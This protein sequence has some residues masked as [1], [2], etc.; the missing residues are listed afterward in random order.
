[1]I[2]PVVSFN[3]NRNVS[4]GGGIRPRF[5]SFNSLMDYLYKKSNNLCNFDNKNVIKLTTKI[6]N[7]D[8][9]AFAKFK[10]GKYAQLVFAKGEESLSKIIFSI[11]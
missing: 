11:T 5:N 8:V 10:D 3:S 9:T 2:Q 6:G 4:F 7:K 1:M